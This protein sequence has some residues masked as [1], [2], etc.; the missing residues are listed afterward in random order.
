[1]YFFRRAYST[2]ATVK[3]CATQLNIPM[4]III[5]KLF[6]TQ[7]KLFFYWEVTNSFLV[8]TGAVTNNYNPWWHGNKQKQVGV[9]AKTDFEKSL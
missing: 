8:A 3:V 5:H 1:M 2:L 6:L 7:A 4:K 9:R